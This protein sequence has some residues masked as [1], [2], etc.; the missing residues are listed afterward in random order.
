MARSK[1][2]AASNRDIEELR[3]VLSLHAI[4]MSEMTHGVLL[5]D[6]DL[7]IVFFN[8]RCT[9]ILNLPQHFIHP[10]LPL[11]AA[12][13]AAVGATNL[14]AAAVEE[15]W[16]ELRPAFRRGE[17]FQFE[18]RIHSDGLITLS[19]RPTGGGGWVCTCEN[20]GAR[21]QSERQLRREVDRL[22]QVFDNMSHGVCL[23]DREQRLIACNDRYRQ[24]YGFRK[25]EIEPG[26]TYRDVLALAIELGIYSGTT[27]DE[28]LRKRN[29]LFTTKPASERLRLSDGRMV[30][31]T[32]RPVG[33][34]GWIAEYEDVTVRM[35]AEETLQARNALLD[36]TLEHMAHGLCA[37][38][39][40]MRVIVVN[41]RYLKM[42]GLTAV[43]ACPGTPMIEL[44]R[45]SI[46]RGVHIPGSKAEDMFADLKER[47][48]DNKEPVL[49]RR[50]A[51]GR[52][53]AVRHQPMAT[54]GWVGTYEDITERYRA[55]QNIAHMAR[56]DALTDLPNRLLFHEQM[57]DGLARVDAGGTL[58]A[59]MCLDLDNFKSINDTLG[60]PV[61]D[62]LLQNVARLLRKTLQHEDTIARLGGDEF[63]IL[64]PTESVADTEAL[65]RRL[66][67]VISRPVV[68]DGQEIVTGLSIGVA[69][70]P[71]NGT[72]SDQLIKCADLALYR[73][74]AMGRNTYLFFEPGMDAEIRAR[75]KIEVDL[76]HALMADDE[77]HLVYQPQVRL[78][79]N[80]IVGMEALIRWTHPDRGLIPPSEFIP[81]A[82]E[83]GLIVQLGEFVLRRACFEAL[84]WPESVR[85]AVNLSPIQIRSRDL[86]SIVTGVLAEAGIA[87]NRLELEITEA[88][89]M[90]KDESIVRTLHDLR[91]LGVR[92]AMD[93][94]GT[95]YSSLS[96]LRSFPFDKIK[97]DRSFISGGSRNADGEPI[98]RA[99]A[100]L[101]ASLGIETTAEG[102]ETFEQLQLVQRA[103][104]TE[105]QGFLLGRPRAKWELN[106]FLALQL[107]ADGVARPAPTNA[108][109]RVV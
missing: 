7:R 10:G 92:I 42:Y 23:Y 30:E 9:E 107:K 17:P 67:G 98:I 43:D 38:D 63:A 50:L 60:H 84:K 72:T 73:A 89:L 5:V 100:Q 56:H 75:R 105:G 66:I 18:R 36:A 93:D 14:P 51:D 106:D 78:S 3:T 45:Q 58:L 15:M 57:S 41:Q 62:K 28:L 90:Q 80:Q 4:A 101:G 21:H 94:F 35:R 96:Y 74:K 34:E 19:C 54:G 1:G 32:V 85:V 37:F 49:H 2:N 53:V 31:L 11:R 65:A 44:M 81:V 8:R 25:E 26:I 39:E 12:L 22:T 52:I 99:I 103:R 59:V 104:C 86:V 102:I 82:E 20:L 108:L 76:R 6:R 87:A 47:L 70:A 64:H 69:I 40:Q 109:R 68:I 29:A 71:E 16:R 61:G 55:E 97:I 13:D 95:G 46:E 33:S 48:I 77:F 83:T 91:T 27:T 79:T 24:I 88:L